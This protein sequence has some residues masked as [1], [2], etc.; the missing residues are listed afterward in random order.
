MSL[1]PSNSPP[2][3][4]RGWLSALWAMMRL[5]CPHCH[6]GR[7][8]RGQFE[9][10]DPCP[11]CGVL[12]QRE[13][14]YFLGAMYF[15]YVLATGVLIPLYVIAALLLPNQGTVVIALVATLAYLPFVPAV[16][17]YSRALWICMDRAVCGSETSAPP[18]EKIRKE[19]L[20][21]QSDRRPT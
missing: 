10:N 7:L 21:E 11:V 6:Q 1:P 3:A 17:R 13:E 19:Q 15:S 14:G 4:A 20:A 18:Y 2:V 12:F 5:R 9:M 8:F 16:F